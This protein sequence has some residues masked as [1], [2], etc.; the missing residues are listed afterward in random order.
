MD[1]IT[2][3]ESFMLSNPYNIVNIW[4]LPGSDFCVDAK[5][6]QISCLRIPYYKEMQSTGGKGNGRKLGL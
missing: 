6:P 1:L 3:Q 5:I 2:L 4:K